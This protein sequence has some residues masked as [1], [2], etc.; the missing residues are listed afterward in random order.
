VTVYDK[1]TGNI[2]LQDGYG[3]AKQYGTDHPR[4]LQVREPGNFQIEFYGNKLSASVN[5]SVKKTGN[6]DEPIV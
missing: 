6:I 4:H 1:A 3:Q 2:V 5:I